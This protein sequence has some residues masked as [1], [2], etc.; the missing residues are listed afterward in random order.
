MRG[1]YF[2][3]IK[4]SPAGSFGPS[5]I[6]VVAALVK[7]PFPSYVSGHS[8]ISGACAEALRLFKGL[9]YFGFSVP[10]TSVK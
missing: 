5:Y 6:K 2:C 1:Y 4:N 10:F 8:T 7:P 9:D 3:V